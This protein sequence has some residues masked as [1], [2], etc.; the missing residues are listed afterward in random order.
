MPPRVTSAYGMGGLRL[1]TGCRDF[2]DGI[3]G[4]LARHRAGGAR[5]EGEAEEACACRRPRA[6]CR[7]KLAG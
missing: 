1:E 3:G 7:F 5:A 6:G 4:K 2:G